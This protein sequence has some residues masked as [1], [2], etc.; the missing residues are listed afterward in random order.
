M[1]LIHDL[2]QAFQHHS[3]AQPAIR[4]S[5]RWHEKCQD[6]QALLEKQSKSLAVAE[7]IPQGDGTQSGGQ[8]VATNSFATRL[9]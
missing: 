3:A 9:L 7:E 4:T 8:G 6:G 5:G 2:N 1:S